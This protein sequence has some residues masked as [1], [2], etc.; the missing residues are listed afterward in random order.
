M[1]KRVYLDIGTLYRRAIPAQATSGG[2]MLK[3]VYLDIGTQYRCAEASVTRR[4]LIICRMAYVITV[5]LGGVGLYAERRRRRRRSGYAMHCLLCRRRSRPPERGGAESGL[6]F[7]VLTAVAGQTTADSS[8]YHVF[9]KKSKCG[10]ADCR[11]EQSR[12][13]RSKE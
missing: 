1:L 6:F 10:I 9:V 3:R 4:G 8:R 7:E 11:A 2:S 12:A 5:R 13:E